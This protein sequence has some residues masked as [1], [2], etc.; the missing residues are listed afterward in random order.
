[1]VEKKKIPAELA[2]VSVPIRKDVNQN[3]IQTA[4]GWKRTLAKKRLNKRKKTAK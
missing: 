3:R 4:E 2:E 1:M